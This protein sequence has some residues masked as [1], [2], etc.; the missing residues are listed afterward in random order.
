DDS[1]DTL[2]LFGVDLTTDAIDSYDVHPVGEEIDELPSLTDPLS[3]LLTEEYAARVG[4]Q[5]DDRVPFASP[6]GIERLHVRGLLRAEGLAT[7]FGGNLAMMD[8]PAAQR[9][10]G[11][12]GRVDQVDVLLRPGADVASVQER[13]MKVLPSSLSV[14]R[15]PPR[16]D[17]LGRGA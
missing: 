12:E 14:I 8:L 11:K 10:L 15:P 6:K 2:Q 5:V 16:A 7:V 1:G 13:L 17:R 4:I 3:V 9:L